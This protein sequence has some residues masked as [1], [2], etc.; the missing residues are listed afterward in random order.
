VKTVDISDYPDVEEVEL[1][2]KSLWGVRSATQ[3][4]GGMAKKKRKRKKL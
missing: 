3:W 2:W 4:K 1:F